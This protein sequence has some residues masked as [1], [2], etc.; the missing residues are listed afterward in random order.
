MSFELPDFVTKVKED[1]GYV[2]VRWNS[3]KIDTLNAE[4]LTKEWFEM[5]NDAFYDKYHF[6]FVPS[7]RLQN[8]YR[9]K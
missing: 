4:E 2:F 8:W 1:I 5:S 9:K 3:G 6:N 7:Q